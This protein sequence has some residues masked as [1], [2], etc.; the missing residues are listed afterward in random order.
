MFWQGVGLKFYFLCWVVKHQCDAIPVQVII[1]NPYTSQIF[2]YCI[3][4]TIPPVIHVIP[5]AMPSTVT[6]LILYVNNI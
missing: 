2:S 1:T 4:R 5:M 6:V 3:I